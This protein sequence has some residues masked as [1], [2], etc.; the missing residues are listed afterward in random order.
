VVERIPSGLVVVVYLPPKNQ[1]VGVD[2]AGSAAS[3]SATGR[4]KREA[5]ARMVVWFE[6]IRSPQN[7]LTRPFDQ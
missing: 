5:S 6:S 1:C 7:S 3:R 4:S 2:P